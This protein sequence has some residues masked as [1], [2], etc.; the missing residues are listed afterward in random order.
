MRVDLIFAKRA[1]N[2]NRYWVFDPQTGDPHDCALLFD[3]Q[4][5]R[6]DEAAAK[7]LA[8]LPLGII[9]KPPTPMTMTSRRD[10]SGYRRV[11]KLK[12]GKLKRRRYRRN[13]RRRG[14]LRKHW[15]AA[16]ERQ[17]DLEA[18]VSAAL[19]HEGYAL[20]EITISE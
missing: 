11:G 15:R 14:I 6:I 13:I 5:E 10:K 8:A 1:R 2:G 18:A 16:G 3:N 19:D 17:K 4:L 20:A 12:C 9:V 7:W